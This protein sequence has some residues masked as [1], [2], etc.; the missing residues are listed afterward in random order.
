VPAKPIQKKEV[1]AA[2][3]DSSSTQ[4]KGKEGIGP[5]SSKSKSV[6]QP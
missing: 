2:K 5:K 6:E 1:E 3:N 4:R